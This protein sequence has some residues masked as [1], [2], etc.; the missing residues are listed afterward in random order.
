M[1]A[2]VP[3]R[4]AV[5]DS[6][7]T[8]ARGGLS[9]EDG[10]HVINAAVIRHMD[11]DE[12]KAAMDINPVGQNNRLRRIFQMLN[13]YPNLREDLLQ[14]SA[15]FLAVN[16]LTIEKYDL[17]N[18]AFSINWY[19]KL[20]S[21]PNSLS[22]ISEEMEEA[23]RISHMRQSFIFLLDL[24]GEKERMLPD[25]PKTT[26]VVIDFLS[27]YGESSQGKEKAIIRALMCEHVGPRCGGPVAHAQLIVE[28]TPLYRRDNY[29][30]Y[31]LI[32]SFRGIIAKDNLE[33]DE[34]AGY[35]YMQEILDEEGI[36]FLIT[37]HGLT[38]NRPPLDPK[39]AQSVYQYYRK[40]YR[41]ELQRL[42][43][44]LPEDRDYRKLHKLEYSM[45]CY[46]AYFNQALGEVLPALRRYDRM[47][48]EVR[49]SQEHVRNL[50]RMIAEAQQRR[51][52]RPAPR[53]ESKRKRGPI[54]QE[55]P[56]QGAVTYNLAGDYKQKGSASSAAITRDAGS[57]SSAR[58]VVNTSEVST[59][60]AAVVALQEPLI[61]LNSHHYRDFKK[62]NG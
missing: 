40:K 6:L 39:F 43:E 27:K 17:N 45:E 12:A 51:Q 1:R 23:L 29:M 48:R 58:V 20:L 25:F 37:S 18:L 21:Q 46:E 16:C 28:L 35:A 54:V 61:L 32:N 13:Y 19:M 14:Y 42:V 49:Q 31:I 55:F 44:Q 22:R 38:E 47:Q 8:R 3:N 57:S 4:D 10:Q 11:A 53:V 26:Y 15:F 41:E 56:K 5:I 7:I 36:S 60:A 52:A 2:G 9:F 62:N 50:Q 34:E 30:D 24:L 33:Q 59:S